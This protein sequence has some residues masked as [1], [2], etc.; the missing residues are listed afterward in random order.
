MMATVHTHAALFGLPIT[1]SLGYVLAQLEDLGAADPLPPVAERLRRALSAFLG[2][3]AL[4]PHDPTVWDP[5]LH[6]RGP[7]PLSEVSP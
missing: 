1:H 2:D 6:L 5:P 7:Q 3:Y 4:A